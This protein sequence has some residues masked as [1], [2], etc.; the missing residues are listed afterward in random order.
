MLNPQNKTDII[1]ITPEHRPPIFIFISVPPPPSPTA[2]PS[3][4]KSQPHNPSSAS[5]SPHPWS[6]PQSLLPGRA[7]GHRRRRRSC[8]CTPLATGRAVLVRVGAPGW[9]SAA[10]R[11]SAGRTR[12]RFWRR[13]ARGGRRVVARGMV[14]LVMLMWLGV[15]GWRFW[16]AGSRA[17]CGWVGGRYPVD[18]VRIVVSQG[19][20][21]LSRWTGFAQCTQSQLQVQVLIRQLSSLH[22]I[23]GNLISH[24]A[25]ALPCDVISASELGHSP[26]FPR[27]A[28]SRLKTAM[29]HRQPPI[30]TVRMHAW[31]RARLTSRIC[32]AVRCGRGRG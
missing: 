22:P 18:F 17:L 2:S 8:A 13:L 27:Y 9:A 32:M 21:G 26:L 5:A 14:L 24:H 10:P 6:S 7:Q 28:R 3:T 12:R 20:E 15:R 11:R 4:S 30:A 23:P 1:F 29:V 31:S 19:M 16:G 25:F